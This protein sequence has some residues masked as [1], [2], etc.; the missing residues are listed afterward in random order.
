LRAKKKR[1]LEE[2]LY[3]KLTETEKNVCRLVDTEE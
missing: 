2:P 3:E 1:L